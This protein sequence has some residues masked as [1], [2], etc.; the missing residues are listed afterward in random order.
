M[1]SMDN[2]HGVTPVTQSEQP[3]FDE[4]Y[5]IDEKH[6]K[7]SSDGDVDIVVVEEGDEI[8]ESGMCYLNQSSLH[9]DLWL[10]DR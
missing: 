4:K 1:A 7:S 5:P 2:H 3:S 6:E 8:R 9:L 10:R